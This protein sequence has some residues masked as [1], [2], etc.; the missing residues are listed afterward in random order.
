[1]APTTETP[2]TSASSDGAE[3]GGGEEHQHERR[4]QTGGRPHAV[5]RRAEEH[6]A[7]RELEEYDPNNN[8]P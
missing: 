1:M 7:R 8:S 2:M 3:G 4:F 6:S 5:E